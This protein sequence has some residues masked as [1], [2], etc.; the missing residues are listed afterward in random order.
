M[1]PCKEQGVGSLTITCNV[2]ECPA[3]SHR[4]LTHSIDIVAHRMLVYALLLAWS[5][6]AHTAHMLNT[7][8]LRCFY[9]VVTCSS[10]VCLLL[11]C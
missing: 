11:M 1:S 8:M 4:M 6:G 2:G 9:L 7:A 3:H 5:L 10:S